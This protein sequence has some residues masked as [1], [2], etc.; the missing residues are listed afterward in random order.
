MAMSKNSPDLV[1]FVNGVLERMRHDDT[2]HTI[3]VRWL[4]DNAPSDVPQAVYQ[5]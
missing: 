1:R 5:D 2:L 4:K 3:N